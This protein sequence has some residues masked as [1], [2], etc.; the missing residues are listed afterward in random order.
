[1]RW[2]RLRR[3]SD[4]S[5]GNPHRDCPIFPQLMVII[6]KI[7]DTL[8]ESVQPAASPDGRRRR[9]GTLSRSRRKQDISIAGDVEFQH[10]ALPAKAAPA[11]CRFFPCQRLFGQAALAPF[12]LRTANLLGDVSL[13]R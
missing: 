10:D 2:A 5:A 7:V 1:M 8:C 3:E 9:G 12:L 6:A 4:D 11:R 13:A